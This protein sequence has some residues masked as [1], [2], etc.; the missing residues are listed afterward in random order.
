MLNFATSLLGIVLSNHPWRNT[1]CSSRSPYLYIAACDERRRE[2]G[3]RKWEKE[4]EE[5]EEKE[6]KLNI[7]T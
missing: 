2:N 5:E 3:R 7:D 4:E 6:E 1:I